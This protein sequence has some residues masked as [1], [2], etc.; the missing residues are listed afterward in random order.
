MAT[1][2]ADLPVELLA[3]IFKEATY[4]DDVTAAV[5][6]FVSHQWK[7]MLPPSSIPRYALNLK[8]CSSAAYLGRLEV[9]KWLRGNGCPWG[10]HTFAY[11]ARG[12]H[13]DILKW[14]KGE[15]GL[16]CSGVSPCG[17]ASSERRHMEC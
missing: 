15:G 14:M 1:T 11:A 9:L 4:N 2:I 12:G 16:P 10:R 5:I 6:P 3:E 13:I 17:Q 8:L 7:V